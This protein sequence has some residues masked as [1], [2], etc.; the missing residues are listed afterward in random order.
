MR[1]GHVHGVKR[2][3]ILSDGQWNLC[4]LEFYEDT[5][6]DHG[7]AALWDAA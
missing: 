4:E 7:E 2:K 5:G 6:L 3:E 1:N